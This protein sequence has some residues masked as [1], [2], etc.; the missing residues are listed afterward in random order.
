[1]D[2]EAQRALHRSL[3]TNV[4]ESTITADVARVRAHVARELRD[5]AD[6]GAVAD[7]SSR[8][9]AE[10]IY[11]NRADA[12]ARV[13]RALAARMA[14]PGKNDNPPATLTDIAA[15]LRALTATVAALAG[16]ELTD[17]SEPDQFNAY[18]ATVDHLRYAAEGVAEMTGWF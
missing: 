8:R 13:V 18:V 16:R 5:H 15:T 3:M 2:S 4:I 6:V 10:T 11:A 17:D 14:G 12:D 7:W 1:M 9:L